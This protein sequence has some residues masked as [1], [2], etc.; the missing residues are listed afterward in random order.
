VRFGAAPLFDALDPGKRRWFAP[1]PIEE[2]CDGRVGAGDADQHA[3]G[4]VAHVTG[5]AAFAGKPPDSGAETHT[6]H[7]PSNQEFRAVHP[8]GYSPAGKLDSSNGKQRMKAVSV[9]S[10]EALQ[11]FHTIRTSF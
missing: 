2:V 1:Q 7:T 9:S 3:R 4:V 11:L 8:S 6:L 10:P 5:Q